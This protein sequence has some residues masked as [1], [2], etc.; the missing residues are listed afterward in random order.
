[1]IQVSVSWF[2]FRHGRLLFEFSDWSDV[3]FQ[4]DCDQKEFKISNVKLGGI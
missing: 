4:Y 3:E 1:M 2:E